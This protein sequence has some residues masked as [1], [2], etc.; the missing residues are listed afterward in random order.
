MSKRLKWAT[1][2]DKS[3]LINNLENRVGETICPTQTSI[4][5]WLTASRDM[6]ITAKVSESLRDLNILTTNRYRQDSSIQDVIES[7][8]L[9]FVPVTFLLPGDYSLFV[10]EFRKSP[11]S[12]WI[13]KPCGRAQGHGI[14]LVTRLSHVRKWAREGK[15]PG[16]NKEPYVISVYIDRPLLIGGKKF[17]LRL[18]VLVTSYRPLKAYMSERAPTPY[19]SYLLHL[20][21]SRMLQY[22]LCCLF[23][24]TIFIICAFH[25]QSWTHKQILLLL[26]LFP[27][28]SLFI[29][30]LSGDLPGN[31]FGPNFPR[32][33]RSRKIGCENV[34][35]RK[36]IW[37]GICN[38]LSVPAITHLLFTKD[39]V[40]V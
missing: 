14:F 8:D 32:T 11:H 34:A 3:V 30:T 24:S 12:T 2:I 37:L 27:L 35:R 20:L 21:Q 36:V 18:Y 10:E 29:P 40:D 26:L 9:N 17:D 25:N 16:G 4:D 28:M 22:F 1:D 6:N 33:G 7:L 19:I 23:I 13:A 15:M 39:A 38:L 31:V 5:L